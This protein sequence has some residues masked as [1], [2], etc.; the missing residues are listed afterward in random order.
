MQKK[1]M[2][3]YNYLQCKYFIMKIIYESKEKYI[4]DMKGM[5]FQENSQY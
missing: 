2:N 1:Y 5:I 4:H 3:S